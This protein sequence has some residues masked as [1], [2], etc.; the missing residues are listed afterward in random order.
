[1]DNPYVIVDKSE[2]DHN[3]KYPV[4]IHFIGNDRGWQLVN[5]LETGWKESASRREPQAHNDTQSLRK[6]NR[7]YEDSRTNIRCE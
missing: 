5:D 3:K 6:L 2:L 4:E 7:Y 1:M